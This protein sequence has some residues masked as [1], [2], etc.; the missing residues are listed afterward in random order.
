MAS[1]K[2]IVIARKGTPEWVHEQRHAWQEKHWH[3]LSKWCDRSTFIH[4]VAFGLVFWS[5]GLSLAL[6]TLGFAP[7]YFFELDAGYH[8]WKKTGHIL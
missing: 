1:I 4:M 5:P 2:T 6:Y 3:A 7:I 8:T